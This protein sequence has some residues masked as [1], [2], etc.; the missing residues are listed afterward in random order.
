MKTG[1]E[2]VDAII[3]GRRMILFAG[4]L[5]HMDTRLPNCVMF[6][7]VMAGAGCVGGRKKNGWSVSWMT[8]ELSVLKRTSGRL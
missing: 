6:G 2:S 5:A 1:S 7:G 4:F 8:S 3:R